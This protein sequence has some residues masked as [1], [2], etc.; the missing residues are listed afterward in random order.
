MLSQ[1]VRSA[2]GHGRR[3]APGWNTQASFLQICKKTTNFDPILSRRL[4][5]S[6]EEE[7]RWYLG[8]LVRVRYPSVMAVERIPL[9]WDSCGRFGAHLRREPLL[10]V[11]SRQVQRNK[12]VTLLKRP[13]S[14]LGSLF[15][16]LDRVGQTIKLSPN[17]SKEDVSIPSCHVDCV[18]VWRRNRVGIL[19]FSYIYA[20]LRLMIKSFHSKILWTLV[21][22]PRT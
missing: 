8:F 5:P 11:K 12:A 21:S 7:S 9:I 10:V 16:Q 18:P 17:F 3:P 15:T 6:E 13:R 22:T 2:G 4:C 14:T 1:S 20:F 19:G